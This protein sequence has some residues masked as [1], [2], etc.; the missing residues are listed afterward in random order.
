M[1]PVPPPYKQIVVEAFLQKT[2][3]D[4]TLGSL[5]W[6]VIVII[7]VVI[8]RN[9]LSRIIASFAFRAFQRRNPRVEEKDFVDL[10]M[11]P[12]GIFLSFLVF[13]AAI[14]PLRFPSLLNIQIHF[15]HTDT[16]SVMAGLKMMILTGCFFWVILRL[17]DFITLVFSL[18]TQVSG[19]SGTQIL[20]FFRDF[21]KAIVVLIAV[22]VIM[23]FL[24]GKDW[25]GKLVG[26]M[27]IGAAALALAAKETIENLIGSFII[28]LDKPFHIGDAVN[29]SGVSG[30]VEKIG[31]RSTRI[32]SDAKTYVTLPNKMIVDSIVDDITLMTQRRVVLK[33]ELDSSASAGKVMQLLEDIQQLLKQDPQVIDNFTL[34][35][36][37]ISSHAFIV[38]IIYFTSVTDWQAFTAHKQQM[39]LGIIRAIESAGVKLARNIESVS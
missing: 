10:L 16:A 27:G 11:K 13:V 28:L 38:Q 35:L 22:I 34:N 24:V 9:F 18:R 14:D 33:L 6:A 30:V 36:N 12:L 31:L 23:K 8:L 4:N 39:I 15:L 20:F 2:F 21:I 1:L 19:P 5:L 17:V 7:V 26:A 29:V 32:R 25:T 37:D 3:L